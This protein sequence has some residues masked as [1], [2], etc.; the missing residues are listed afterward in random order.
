MTDNT[1]KKS[2]A[3]G[4][5]RKKANR[6]TYE[7]ILQAF[8]KVFASNGYEGASLA[9][10]AREV[11]IK[12]PALYYHFKSKHE[13]FFTYLMRVGEVISDAVFQAVQAAEDSPAE[14]LKAYVRAIIKVELGMHDMMPMLNALVSGSAIS[15]VLTRAQ[16]N[17]VKNWQRRIVKLLTDILE[18]GKEQGEFSFEN[19]RTA[20]Y[21]II[22][23][24]EYTVTVNWYRTE[25]NLTDERI[26]DQFAELALKAVTP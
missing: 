23:A 22:G 6:D 24:F 7:E 13:I 1:N 2:R 17:W 16:M 19:T 12:T 15:K 26:A 20:A 14:Q 21:F 18:R 5:E 11:G 10:I 9:E 25:N 3:R 8:G 4:W